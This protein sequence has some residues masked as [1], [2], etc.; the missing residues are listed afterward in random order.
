[1][2]SL[3][4]QHDG[5]EAEIALLKR[6]KQN[7]LPLSRTRPTTEWEWMF[8]M[9][10]H[11]VPTRLLDWTESPLI[12][13]YFSV[14]ENPEKDGALWCLNP[15]KLNENANVTYDFTLE[16]SCFDQ[17]NILDS[18]LPTKLASER[19]TTLTPLAA[20][21]IRDNPRVFAQLGNFTITHR[22]QTAI[23][24]VGSSD[25]IW[26][27]K[28]PSASKETIK[29]QLSSIRITKLT[30]FPELDNVALVAKE[31]LR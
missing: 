31:I 24:S 25:H 15:T 11:G 1:M 12:G 8:L 28:I 19:R 10:H 4:R 13:L 18:Y 20:M 16:I 14:Y 26:R 9:Q 29:N 6:F 17:D 30:L 5:V 2:P 22:T 7:A 27:F 23:E 3:A 21:A